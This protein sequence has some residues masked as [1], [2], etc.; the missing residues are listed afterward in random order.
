MI[1]YLKLNFRELYGLVGRPVVEFKGPCEGSRKPT[2]TQICIH[3]TSIEADNY[4]LVF[5]LSIGGT[6]L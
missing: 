3:F 2:T 6:S 4:F 1:E 5:F